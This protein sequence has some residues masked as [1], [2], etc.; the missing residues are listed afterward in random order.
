VIGAKTD[1]ASGPGVG[2]AMMLVQDAGVGKMILIVGV[3]FAG[4]VPVVVAQDVVMNNSSMMV[5]NLLM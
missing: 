2:A 5:K 1:G 4:G 3:A